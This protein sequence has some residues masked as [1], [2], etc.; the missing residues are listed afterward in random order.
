MGAMRSPSQQKRM[1]YSGAWSGATGALDNTYFRTLLAEDWQ[2]GKS[3]GGKD[4]WTAKGKPGV[5]A[6]AADVAVATDPELRAI[7]KAYAED[8]AKFLA[9][10]AKAWTYMMDADRFK[11]PRGSVCGPAAS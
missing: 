11:G 4:E 10:F 7:A 3:A 9:D 2:K 5:Y 1:G 6:T 8:G